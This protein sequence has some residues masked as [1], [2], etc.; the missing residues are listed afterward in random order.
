LDD[1][2]QE[3]R[4]AIE[5]DAKFGHASQPWGSWANLATIETHAG[6]PAAA[7]DARRKALACYLAYRRD[8]GE[9]D[10]PEGR[11]AL[12]VTESLLAGHASEAAAL[13]QQRA[14]RPDA[15]GPFLHAL[16]AVVAGSRDRT[17][18]D[19]PDLHYRMAAELLLLI[20]T[21]ERAGT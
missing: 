2:R 13:L 3:V 8:G 9:N 1:A 5:C 15:G 19:A 10:F 16:Q 20:E 6:N 18:A 4:R 14:V 7:A 12:D 21:L 11:V 17:L